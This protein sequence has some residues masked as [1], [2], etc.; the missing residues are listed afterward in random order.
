MFPGTV[1]PRRALVLLVGLTLVWG[2]NW[3]VIPYAVREVSV[4][5]FRGVALFGAGVTLLLYARLRGMAM[6]IARRHWKAM[7]AA[8]LSYLVISNVASTYAAISIPSGQAAVLTFTMPLW[9]ALINWAVLGERPAA[10]LLLAIALGGAGVALL[11]LRG[12]SA[13]ASAPL[14]FAVGLL[15][16]LGWA[17]GT[18]II[19]RS[20]IPVSAIVLTGWQLVVASVPVSAMALALSDT[21]WFVPG[22][23]SIAAIAWIMLVPMAVGNAVW[24]AIVELLPAN[25]AGLS[26]V[27]VPVV[28]MV[29]GALVHGEPLG[30]L[31]LVSMLCCVVALGLALGPPRPRAD[32]LR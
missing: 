21:P 16:G 29:S 20:G 9:V 7:L 26:S 30:A 14:G 3:P 25:V 1:V 5:T 15:A 17:V 8:T 28:A 31:Q 24:F 19:K 18:L 6:G 13:Y 23:P 27:M 32:H 22:W 10:R 12:L 2:T 4:W 11:L